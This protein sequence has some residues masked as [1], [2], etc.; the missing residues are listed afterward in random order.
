MGID[1]SGTLSYNQ[2]TMSLASVSKQESWRALWEYRQM[3]AKCTD[4]ELQ[5]VY[6]HIDVLRYPERYRAVLDEL[7]RRGLHP[8]SGI[9]PQMVPLN[10]PEQVRAMPTLKGH[11]VLSA[12]VTSLLLAGY[13]AAVTFLFCLPIYLLALPLKILNQQSAFF[14]LLFFPFAPLS[15]AGFGRRAGGTGWYLLSVLAG[16][17]LGVLLFVG[18]GTLHAVVEALFRSGGSGGFSLPATY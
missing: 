7:A 2:T 6:F 5:D 10:V 17:V 3:L 12:V 4:E 15:A 8:V 1:C 14:Y 18:T 13:S 11:P 16:V 9:E